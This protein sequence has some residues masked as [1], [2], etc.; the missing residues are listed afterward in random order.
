MELLDFPR[1]RKRF[2]LA[3]PKGRVRVFLFSKDQ[4]T[5]AVHSGNAEERHRAFLSSNNP[6][7]DVGEFFCL[8][9]DLFVCIGKM[10]EKNLIVKRT[11]VSKAMRS[12]YD[13]LKRFD[14]TEIVFED[15][16]F[17]EDA[18]F[19][20]ILASYTYDFLKKTKEEFS[21]LLRSEKYKNIIEV[22]HVQNIA[23]FLGDTPANLMTPAAFAEYARK[24][25]EGD[26]VII[27]VHSR[28]YMV[29]NQM[30]L[31][32]CVSQ[33]SVE[34]PKLLRV[35]YEGKPQGPVDVALAR[36]YASTVVE[37]Q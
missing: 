17:A 2:E 36:A 24:I 34:E 15:C 28:D 8:E 23:R 6:R 14:K 1:L 30:N 5:I 10:N 33:G 9:R 16:E 11:N 3:D 26:N 32:L 37:S 19:S 27:D 12:L 7:G 22:A 21:F 31:V 35:R 18:I 25:F 29:Q 4:E 13:N 20:L